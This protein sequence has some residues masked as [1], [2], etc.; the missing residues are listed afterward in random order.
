M[1][2]FNKNFRQDWPTKLTLLG[3]I[4]LGM[5]GL[6]SAFRAALWLC[7]AHV[8]NTLTVG[9]V[10]HAFLYGLW[11]DISIICLFMAPAAALFLL[12]LKSKNWARFC[13][14]LLLTAGV[15]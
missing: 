2:F 3:W 10:V 5:L 14:G 11:F 4:G 8:F 6:L 15:V 7:Y 12:P 1:H 9:Q 13:L